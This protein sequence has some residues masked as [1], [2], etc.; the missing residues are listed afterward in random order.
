MIEAI[1]LG[2]VA[3]L[4]IKVI[5]IDRKLD[6]IIEHLKQAKQEGGE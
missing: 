4:V 6:K 5:D 3:Y 2:W 1:T